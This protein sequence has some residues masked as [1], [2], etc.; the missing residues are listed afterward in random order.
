MSGLI[1]MGG[2][3]LALLLVLYRLLR[4]PGVG[5][6]MVAADTLTVIITALIPLLAFWLDAPLLLDLTLLFA[7]LAFV[8]VVVLARVVMAARTGAQQ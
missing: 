5:D 4:G 7:L 8:G 6:R 1:V 2:I 3:A